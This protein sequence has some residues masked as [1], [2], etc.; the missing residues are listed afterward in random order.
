MNRLFW[1]LP[2]AGDLLILALLL[3]FVVIPACHPTA[4][5]VP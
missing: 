3:M 4:P 1:I 2:V 5:G